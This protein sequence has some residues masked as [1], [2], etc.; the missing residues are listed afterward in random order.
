LFVNDFDGNGKAEQIICTF[1]GDDNYPMALRHDLVMQLPHLK[2]KI[3]KYNAYQNATMNDLFS[4]EEMKNTITLK[5]Q[6]FESVVLIND[7]K[8]K[9]EMKPLPKIAQ[10]SP[11]YAILAKDV[12]ND[13]NVDILLGGNLYGAKPEVGRYDANQGLM[14]KGD[15]TGNFTALTSAQSGFFVDGE[16]RDLVAIKVGNKTVIMAAR[17]NDSLVLFEE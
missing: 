17:N 3:L 16:M 15:S 14:L 8:G 7:G 6:T 4:E 1:N 9:L 10:A 5:A 11:I 12:D 2:K 13:G